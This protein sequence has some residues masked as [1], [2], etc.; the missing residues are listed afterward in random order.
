MQVIEF[1]AANED[2][3][4]VI[5]LLE[6]ALEKARAGQVVDA[7]VVLAIQDGDGPQFWHSDYGQRAYATLLAGVS[8]L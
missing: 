8:A 4:T 3:E 1:Q 7:A 6:G 5:S 2:R